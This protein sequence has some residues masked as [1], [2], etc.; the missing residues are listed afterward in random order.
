MRLRTHVG[1]GAALA[2]VVGASSCGKKPDAAAVKPAVSETAGT[3]GQQ[4]RPRP[5][6]PAVVTLDKGYDRMKSRVLVRK[7][8]SPTK[9]NLE[10]AFYD[11][12]IM[13]QDPQKREH[14]PLDRKL[15]L[16]DFDFGGLLVKDSIV[17]RIEQ[18]PL[19]AD[20]V[21]SPMAWFP[22]TEHL[23]N[24]DWDVGGALTEAGGKVSGER[25]GDDEIPVSLQ[26]ITRAYIHAAAGPTTQI[27]VRVE[28][29]PWV[30]FLHGVDDE[31]ADGYPELYAALRADLVADNIV[32]EL[33]G[34]YRGTVLTRAQVL[35]D[36]N[37]GEGGWAFELC[38]YLYPKYN[39]EMLDAK[40][41]AVF[42]DAEARP[43]VGTALACLGDVK[44]DLVIAARPFEEWHVWNVFV[45]EG[46]AE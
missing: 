45:I 24:W 32:A 12:N 7:V 34:A 40:Q 38:S 8:A 17:D 20:E 14:K 2:L 43:L 18:T 10:F 36:P 27:W 23:T 6:G 37:T 1:L 13:T 42:P 31:D 35:G 21:A 22:M 11:A 29:K 25:W 44:P 39:T 30:A 46:F 5:S 28:F 33:V 26:E 16:T 41:R 4:V 19:A 9:A 15:G 3:Q